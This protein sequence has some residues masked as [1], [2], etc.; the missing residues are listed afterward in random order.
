MIT[1]D[2]EPFQSLAVFQFTAF[3]NQVGA[4]EP[5]RWAWSQPGKYALKISNRELGP[6]R[7]LPLNV[8]NSVLWAPITN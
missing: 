7:S 6:K 5:N 3:R 2:Q 4:S 1:L 8:K